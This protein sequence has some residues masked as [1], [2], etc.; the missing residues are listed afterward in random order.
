MEHAEK[1]V[2]L[3]KALEMTL[4]CIDSS[5]MVELMMLVL[6]K[7]L[8]KSRVLFLPDENLQS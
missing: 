4:S 5:E 6:L 2:S 8:F 1:E 3:N 7:L